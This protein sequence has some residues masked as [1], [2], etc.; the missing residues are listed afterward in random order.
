M[1]SIQLSTH[2]FISD[3]LHIFNNIYDLLRQTRSSPKRALKERQLL[4]TEGSMDHTM[5]IHT[6]YHSELQLKMFKQ[7]PPKITTKCYRGYC[8][9]IEGKQDL[10][11]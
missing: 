11:T 10:T 3:L 7:I 8:D 1:E 9:V 4:P 5:G 2:P 6:I